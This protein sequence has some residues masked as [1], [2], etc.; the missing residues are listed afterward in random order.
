MKKYNSHILAVTTNAAR[1]ACS[2]EE[3]VHV[4]SPFEEEIEGFP[5]HSNDIWVGPREHLE[6]MESFKQIIP[7]VVVTRDEKIL[8][9]KRT[10]KG[11]EA[12]LHD[13][14]S[15][16]FGGHIDIGDIADK[17]G[18]EAI[19]LETT[20]G[21]AVAREIA[22]ELKTDGLSGFEAYG[23]ILDE[24]DAVGRVHLGVVMLAKVSGIVLSRE[25]QIE[26]MGFKSIKDIVADIDN[27]ENWSKIIVSHI[28]ETEKETA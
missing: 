18:G 26:L 4:F 6:L 21:N 19:D 22:E 5:F 13:R 3:T 24:S 17:N 1:A 7:Y 9:Y 14:L 23:M 20:I 15:I 10:S 2:S 25:D 8:V 27:Y 11:G 28:H 12:R 16:G